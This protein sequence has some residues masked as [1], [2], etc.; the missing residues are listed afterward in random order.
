M[1]EEKAVK[2]VG[3]WTPDEL[4]QGVLAG[5]VRLVPALSKPR[6]ETF[7]VGDPIVLSR[8]ALGQRYY[9]LAFHGTVGSQ[10]E[11]LGY[12]CPCGYTPTV[13]VVRGATAVPYK[14]L[15]KVRDSV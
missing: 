5:Y 3:D 8:I 14:D 11:V 15:L 4:W 12:A 1:E 9:P 7:S 6:E 10:L 13:H 2:G